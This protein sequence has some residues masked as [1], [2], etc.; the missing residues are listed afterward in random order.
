MKFEVVCGVCSVTVSSVRCSLPDMNVWPV[1]RV[2]TVED[3]TDVKGSYE[4]DCVLKIVSCG[5]GQSLFED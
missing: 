1:D 3:G 5:V 2:G 4:Y